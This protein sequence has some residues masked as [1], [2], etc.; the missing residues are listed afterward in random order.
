[1][2]LKEYLKKKYGECTRKRERS[3]VLD[4]YRAAFTCN[5]KSAIRC[6]N[7]DSNQ[8]QQKRGPAPKYEPDIY[9]HIIK[10]KLNLF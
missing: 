1:M 5:R 8:I 9:L 6:L 7:Q 3:A 4:E 10:A 2:N